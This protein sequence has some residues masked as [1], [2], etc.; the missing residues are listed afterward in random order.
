MFLST[1]CDTS[2]RS[3]LPRRAGRL[4]STPFFRTVHAA[5]AARLG[6]RTLLI[7]DGIDFQRA[8]ASKPAR[9]TR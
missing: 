8:Q 2:A 9:P 4:A 1:A 6:Y 3:G 7:L 5:T